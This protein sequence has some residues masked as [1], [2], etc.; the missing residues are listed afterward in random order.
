MRCLIV[1]RLL[2]MQ[3]TYACVLSKCDSVA[4]HAMGRKDVQRVCYIYALV[5]NLG[6]SLSF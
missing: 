6:E 1:T 2:S 4:A 3:R 5:H